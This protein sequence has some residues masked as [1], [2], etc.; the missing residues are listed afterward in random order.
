MAIL[1]SIL[2]TDLY[3]LTMMKAVLDF[4]QNILVR[5][6]FSNRRPEGKFNKEFADAFRRELEAM[7]TLRLT[8]EEARWL[9]RECPFLGLEYIA[10]LKGYEYN[11]D[12]VEFEI[13]DGE[14][15]LS[16]E[17]SWDRTIL[18]EVPLMAI[19]SELYFTHCDKNWDYCGRSY[20]AQHLEKTKILSGSMWADFGTRRR[21]AYCV[22]DLVVGASKGQPGFVGTSNVHLAHKN[23]VKP[24]GT[25]A[26][27]WVMGISALEGL[28]YANRH[29]LR[30]WSEIYQG[31]LGI[32]LPD[33]FGS[34]AFFKDFDLYLAKLFDGIRHDSGNPIVFGNRVISHYK[35]LGIDPMSK[36]IVF[37]DGLD[38]VTVLEIGDR[39][40]GK[41]KTSFGIGT[42]FTNDIDGSPALNMV[43]KMWSCNGIPVVKLS[44]SK[45]K[46]MGDADALRVAN[47]TFTGQP[48]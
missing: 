27:E 30:I 38:P 17:G 3:K 24:I 10:Y 37:S 8:E 47:W 14:L 25:M 20:Q 21:R 19:I 39:F 36:V 44:D 35:S 6:V 40:R 42:N 45:G 31:N 28:R 41:I 16:V 12:E 43:I 26:H 23:G 22:Q 2:D 48:L 46:Q 33:T 1:N 15:N 9:A 32:A 13:K 7:R 29:A 34:D 4:Y 5:Y 11:P 18:W